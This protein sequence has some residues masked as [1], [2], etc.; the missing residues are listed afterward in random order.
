MRS[1]HW[2]GSGTCHHHPSQSWT[3]GSLS[4]NC[5]DLVPGLC[6]RCVVE[7][8]EWRSRA[9]VIT[10]DFYPSSGTRNT[11]REIQGA[12]LHYFCQH[13]K[14]H[15]LP[16]LCMLKTAGWPW[17]LHG[18]RCSPHVPAFPEG[19]GQSAALTCEWRPASLT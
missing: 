6:K 9:Y 10:S 4:I 2:Q 13:S 5:G 18:I 3:N 14:K 1:D 8:K 16:Q 15:F 19:R 11:L 17:L 7:D 12:L